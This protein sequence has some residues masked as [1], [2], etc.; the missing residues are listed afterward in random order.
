MSLELSRQEYWRELPFSSPGDLP[1]SGIEPRFP[2]LQ[3]EFLTPELTGK[4]M[5]TC[6]SST[7]SINLKDD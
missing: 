7:L 4:P 6:K 2:A 1:H 3:A 5:K